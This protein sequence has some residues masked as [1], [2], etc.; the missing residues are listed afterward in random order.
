MSSVEI[1]CQNCGRLGSFYPSPSQHLA[2]A[3]L[4][5]DRLRA[6]HIHKGMVKIHE[7]ED[8]PGDVGVKRGASE[9]LDQEP[10]RPELSG[11]SFPKSDCY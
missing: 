7:V 2:G 11:D 10:K 9:S 3:L 8:G 5:A 4:R 1:T 6:G